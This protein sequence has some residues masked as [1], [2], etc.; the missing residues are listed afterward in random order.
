MEQ[1]GSHDFQTPVALLV[2]YT[3]RLT[4]K[5]T[6]AILLGILSAAVSASPA[7]IE[8]DWKYEHGWDGAVLPPTAIGTPVDDAS[9][10]TTLASRAVRHF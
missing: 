4:M 3:T 8:T 9:S 5:T 10:N 7:S 2:L 6:S 1:G